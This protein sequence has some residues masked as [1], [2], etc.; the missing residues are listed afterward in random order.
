[1]SVLQHILAIVGSRRS[2]DL[3]TRRFGPA[4]PK[5]TSGRP[6]F[7][8]P[9]LI[10]IASLSAPC[11]SPKR[12][13][14]CPPTVNIQH[15]T[16]TNSRCRSDRGLRRSGEMTHWT[17]P[18]RGIRVARAFHRQIEGSSIRQPIFPPLASV[19]AP[20]RNHGIAA[21]SKFHFAKGAFYDI[22]S[23]THDRRHAGAKSRPEHP[24]FLRATGV[25]VRTPTSTSR[26]KP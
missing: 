7:L 20:L 14:V 5:R 11:D 19:R 16:E 25:P 24:N 23:S 15:G 10:P 13:C 26:R 1:V 3:P 2:S 22:S 21:C 9:R 17:K 18:L 8:P 4:F 6:H 12:S